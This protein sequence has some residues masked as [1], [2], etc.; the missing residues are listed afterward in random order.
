MDS[1]NTRDG[2]FGTL[3]MTVIN[4]DSNQVQMYSHN[5]D[6]IQSVNE[7]YSQFTDQSTEKEKLPQ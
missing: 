3:D 2:F 1:P 4:Q 5:Q 7:C 6:N